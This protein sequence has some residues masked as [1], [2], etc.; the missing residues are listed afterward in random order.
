MWGNVLQAIASVGE[1]TFREQELVLGIVGAYHARVDTGKHGGK[2][3]GAVSGGDIDSLISDKRTPQ[4]L[5]WA[6]KRVRKDDVLSGMVVNYTAESCGAIGW[7]FTNISGGDCDFSWKKSGVEAFSIAAG[8]LVCAGTAGAGCGFGAMVIAGGVSGGLSGAG[9]YLVDVSDG[10]REFDLG[11]LATDTLVGSAGGMVGGAAFFGVGKG[12]SAAWGKFVT[13]RTA[14]PLADDIASTATNTEGELL[15]G[16]S[17]SNPNPLSTGNDEAVFWSGIGRGG[18][19]T[20]SSWAAKNGGQTLEMTLAKRGVPLPTTSAGWEAASAKFAAGASGNVRVL[21][22]E[23]R[24]SSTW[25]R[26]EY[27]A[28][29]ANPNVMSITSIDPTTGSEVVLWTR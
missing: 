8:A 3:D 9:D 23:V 18:D 2:A 7:V 11:D 25:A 1:G 4:N 5:L 15:G 21:Q 24:L 10:K 13:S 16:L 20:A 22:S 27:G 19:A 28:L 29:N 26:V 6:L 14:A 17:S 12:L